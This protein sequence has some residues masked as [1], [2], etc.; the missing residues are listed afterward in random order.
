MRIECKIWNLFLTETSVVDFA[1]VFE[2]RQA[3]DALVIIF[4]MG[5]EIVNFDFVNCLAES[6]TRAENQQE[7]ELHFHIKQDILG[8]HLTAETFHKN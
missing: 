8:E 6:K 2:N 3:A 5:D 1:A 7:K 4:D